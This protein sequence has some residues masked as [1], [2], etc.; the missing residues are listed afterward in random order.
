MSD[1]T[2]TTDVTWSET[3]TGYRNVA[4]LY[5]ESIQDFAFRVTG[6]ADNWTTIVELNGLAWPY[7]TTDPAS[8]S[9]AVGFSGQA[10]LKV[11]SATTSVSGVSDANDIYG[12][13]W[14]IEDGDFAVGPNGDFAT[15]AGDDNLVQAVELRLVNRQGDLI[16]HPLYGQT[17][18]K[19][20][21]QSGTPTN[22]L[23]AANRA[24]AAV[25]ADPRIASTQ[26]TI[27]TI[28][29]DGC[30]IV[31]TAIA[32]DGRAIPAATKLT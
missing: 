27:A 19:L 10:S 18:Y 12:T 17:I 21:G 2:S 9:A 13:D 20:L 1:T 23:L 4:T 14:A 11:I 32:E 28:A 15:V 26:N 24:A 7:L 25:G 22:N 5:G 29:G 6:D 31:M 16:R 3:V 30:S 8:V